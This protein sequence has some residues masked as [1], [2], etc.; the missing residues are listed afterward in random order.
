MVYRIMPRLYYWEAHMQPITKEEEKQL[1]TIQETYYMRSLIAKLEADYFKKHGIVGSLDFLHEIIVPC[2][3]EVETLLVARKNAGKI[4]SL[5]Q[6]RKSV[7]GNIFPCAIIY[8]FLRAKQ[9]GL[10][11]AN[12]FATTKTKNALFEKYVTIRVGEETQ[13][14]DMDLVF[15]KLDAQK[16]LMGCMIV[17]LKTSLRDRT[18]KTHIWKLLL[19]I[20]STD[21]V[22]KDKYNIHFDVSK[23]PTVCFATINFYNEI[24]NPQHRGMFKFFDGAFIGKPIQSDFINRLSELF[25]FADVATNE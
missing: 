17:N 3:D 14:P 12:L 7:V 21:N 6:A 4:T 24:N 23:T 19:E 2:K 11:A 1:S 10:V 18:R 15:Y 25:A 13:K 20:A 22:I 9:E 5:D 16:K 8:M